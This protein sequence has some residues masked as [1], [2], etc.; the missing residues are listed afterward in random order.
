PFVGQYSILQAHFHWGEDST[1]GSEHTVDGYRYPMEMHIVTKMKF[2]TS[3]CAELAVL[4]FFFEISNTD[5]P[6]WNDIITGLG[7]ITMPDEETTLDYINLQDLLPSDMSEFYSYFGSLT[8]PPYS[9]II[10]WTVFKNTIKISEYQIAQF[11]NLLNG[12][13]W[14]IVDNFR[15]VQLL[16]GRTVYSN[17]W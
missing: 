1:K 3:P 14:S 16:N 8:T 11:R 17:C 12:D 6:A 7:E 9:Q 4:G 5:N 15:P 2:G 13:E 10:N